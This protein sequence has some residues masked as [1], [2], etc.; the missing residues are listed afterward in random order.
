MYNY[1]INP[2][3]GRKVKLNG[4]LGRKILKKY[5]LISNLVSNSNLLFNKQAGGNSLNLSH[6]ELNKIFGS[7]RAVEKPTTI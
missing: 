3:T 5:L 6:S 7:Y 4:R 2:E 1:I